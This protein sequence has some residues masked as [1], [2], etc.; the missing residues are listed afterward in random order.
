MLS[1]PSTSSEEP[2]ALVGKRQYLVTYSQVDP[3]IF[4][5]K[6]S[7]GAALEEEFNAG[8]GIVKVEYWA[9]CREPHAN[10]GF[11][12]HCSLKLTG[13]KKWIGIKRRLS[14][15]YNIQ[16]NFSDKHD[17]YLSSYR[18]VRKSDKEVAHSTN[19]PKDLLL[20]TSPRTKNCTRA[21][22]EANKKRRESSEKDTTKPKRLRKLSNINAAEMIKNENINNYTELLALAETRREAGQNDLAE[23]VFSKI[24]K[25]L[26]E[27]VK[28]TWAMHTARAD[29]EKEKLS[30]MD[31]L[32]SYL[33]PCTPPCDGQWLECAK[34]VLTLNNIS[35]SDFGISISKLIQHGRGKH[36]NILIIGPANCAK[37]FILNPLQEIFNGTIF[38]NPAND[39]YG[40]VGA[41]KA[42]V[43]F[44]NDFRWNKELINWKDLLLL[45]EGEPVRLPA[46]KNMYSEDVNITSNVPIFATSKST[47]RYR[48]SYGTIDETEDQMMNVRWKLFKFSHQF[49]ECNQKNISPCPKCFSTLVLSN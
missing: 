27:L 43:I 40:W 13:S 25:H 29:L 22:I 5:T 35:I 23:Y 41:D 20:K 39:K 33:T 30:R 18:Y 24:E 7:F 11:H 48:G 9:C 8:P 4:P 28:K 26:H 14:V 17:L 2:S 12:Y 32:Q 47:I 45:L 6:E 34:E 31:M 49:E 37:T 15:K 42:R 21:S 10:E 16:V 46:P 1:L 36:R 19:H 44:L 38:H 3:A